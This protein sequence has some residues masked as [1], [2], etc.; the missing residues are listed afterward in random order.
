MAV[1][2]KSSPTG[3]TKTARRPNLRRSSPAKAATRTKSAFSAS[4]RGARTE[5]RIYPGIGIARVGDSKDG[6]IIGPEA[7]RVAPEGPYRGKD[8]GIKP[9]GARFRVF[10]VDIDANENETVRR[11]VTGARDVHIEWTVHLANRKAAARQ[12]FGDDGSGT[13]TRNT[14]ARFRNAG[15]DRD[16]LVIASVASIKNDAGAA[17]TAMTGSIAFAKAGKVR[18]RVDDILLATL[19]TDDAG[20]LIVVGGPGTAGSPTNAKLELFSDNDGW[21]DSVSDGPVSATLRIGKTSHPVIPAWVMVTVPRYAPEVYGIVTWFD[22]ALNMART[23]EDGTFDPPRTTS[24]LRDVYP[25]LKRTDDVAAVHFTVH[26][27][28]G[29]PLTSPERLEKLQR[30]GTARKNLLNR[31]TLP[32]AEVDSFE[33]VPRTQMPMLNSGANP[34]PKGPKWAFFSVTPYQLAHLQ[35]WALGDYANDWPGAEPKPPAFEQIPV[36]RQPHALNE[37]ALEACVGGPFFPGIEGTYDITRISTYHPERY[38]RQEFRIDPR[39]PAGSLAE[40]MALPWQ[41]DFADCQRFWWPSQRPVAVTT[42]NGEQDQQ[43]SRGINDPK[44]DTRHRNMV[45]F[46]SRLAFIVRDD[47]TGT[48]REQDRLVINGFG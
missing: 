3:R 1:K 40:K 19:R 48:F 6:F 32:N 45:S 43:W 30:D 37:A 28:G 41:A 5:Y 31:L 39:Q 17:A 27:T 15:F 16:K 9:Q 8:D 20:R 14:A 11:E 35:H 23:S 25:I 13:L 10:Q 47:A 42:K 46:W 2:R 21:Y 7:P 38:L 29:D 33:R 22:Q 34:D 44:D 4:S 12:I 18:H 26:G 36:D 24:F